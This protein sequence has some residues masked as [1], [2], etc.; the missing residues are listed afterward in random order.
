M[1]SSGKITEDEA[2]HRRA[3]KGSGEFEVIV[4]LS[5]RDTQGR[6]WTPP[7]RRER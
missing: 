1:V 6:I 7:S 4:V 3:T 5:E 2:A